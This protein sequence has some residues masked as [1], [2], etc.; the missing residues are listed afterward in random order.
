MA[1][2]LI[3]TD[4]V[5][6]SGGVAGRAIIAVPPEKQQMIGVRFVEVRT[7]EL[8]RVIRTT[9]V[10][11]HDETRQV[12]ISPRFAG[13]VRKLYVNYTGQHVEK[14]A[15]LLTVYSPELLAAESE[16]LLA[17]QRHEK[18]KASPS[19]A[20]LDAARLL[21]ES[22][23]RRLALWEIGDE[24]I[25]ELEKSGK[26]RDEVLL[27]SP[28][29]GHVLTRDAT[30]GKGFMAGETLYTIEDL[31]RVWLRTTIYESDFPRVKVG[32][33][34][35]VKFPALTTMAWE[36]E[37]TFIDPHIDP[38]TRRGE[39]RLELDNPAHRFRPDMWA[40]VEIELPLGEVLTVPASAVIDTG[41]RTLAF[42]KGK[43]NHFEPREVTI[44][45][46]LDDL[47]EVESGLA[48][49]DQVVERALFLIDSES[50]LKAAIAGMSGGHKH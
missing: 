43:D 27:R 31:S 46:R 1:L 24:E 6:Q 50:Q 36:S 2:V 44:G 7:Q 26:P 22:A 3:K 37:V 15:P 18:L 39:V 45:A 11:A 42:V 49:G 25:A 4:G 32:L 16:Y 10:V 14:G 20:Q 17:H 30:E 47:W 29:S 40:E 21:A 41:K 19:D 13:W 35:R 12:K 28:A 34:A 8:A 23:R 38:A 33:K 5:S 9:A 48:A